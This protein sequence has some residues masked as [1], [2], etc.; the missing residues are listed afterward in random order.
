MHIFCTSF[1]SGPGPQSVGV[2]AGLS[3]KGDAEAEGRMAS[4]VKT[5][6]EVPPHFLRKTFP[7]PPPQPPFQWLLSFSG[8]FTYPI[9]CGPLGSTAGAQVLPWPQRGAERAGRD[10]VDLEGARNIPPH[11]LPL[12]GLSLRP[13]LAQLAGKSTSAESRYLW[14]TM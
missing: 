12:P 2:E 9:N 13:S 5:R 4:V 3:R 10:S 8:A 6:V 1:K 14:K 11:S 7:Q